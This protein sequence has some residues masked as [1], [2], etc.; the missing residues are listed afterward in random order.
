MLTT[1]AAIPHAVAY[2]AVLVLAVLLADMRA[3]KKVS[4]ELVVSLIE[5]VAELEQD[6]RRRMQAGGDRVHDT[7]DVHAQNAQ[8]IT[9]TVTRLGAGGGHRRMQGMCDVADVATRV[10]DI[11]AECCDEPDEDCSGGYPHTCNAGCAQLLLPFWSDC[12]DALGQGAAKFEGAVG[13]CQSVAP[14]PQGTVA[15]LLSVQCTDASISE[16]DC[17]PDCVDELH[18]FILLLNIDGGDNKL[19][20]ELHHG[21]YSWVGSASDGGFIGMDISTFVSAVVSGAPGVFFLN[22]LGNSDVETTLIVQPGQ[23]VNI[24]GTS[25]TVWGRGGMEVSQ[26]SALFLEELT[27]SGPITVHAGGLL[28]VHSVAF[29]EGGCATVE[30]MGQLIISPGSASPPQC[31][32]NAGCAL[33][34]HCTTPAVGTCTCDTCSA[35]FYIFR[36]DE[37]PGRCLANSVTLQQAGFS[38][39]SVGL[40]SF[41]FAGSVPSD[42]AN[43][44]VTVVTAA[45]LSLTGTGAETIGASFTV[46]GG[47]LS[48]ERMAMSAASFATAQSSVA[49]STL[50]LSAVTIP[51]APSA[52]ELTGT[53]TVLADGSTTMEPADLVADFLAV[54][55]HFIVSSGP[56]T[57]SELGRCVGRPAGYGPDEECTIA[58]GSVGGVLGAC[59]VFDMFP[60]SDYITLPNASDPFTGSDCPVGAALAPADIVSWRSDSEAQGNCACSLPICSSDNGCVVKGLCGLPCTYNGPGGEVMHDCAP[61]MC[62]EGFYAHHCAPCPNGLGGGWQICFR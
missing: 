9:R 46:S 24:I 25:V 34:D 11:N 3:E 49:G 41:T 5:R 23:K 8:I 53:E 1:A 19:S 39:T 7:V 37:E 61:T 31:V 54:W 50:R 26:G 57:V 15:Q 17:I 52:G 14:G 28:T 20:C 58:V 51:E 35:G 59:G 13:L 4:D 10:V 29:S 62:G 30:D 36:H 22:V 45:S 56:C 18:G 47:T 38:G 44:E 32:A 21:L 16:S 33:I 6:G 48:V 27:I 42:L 12:R 60:W 55:P 43:G 2:L 40:F